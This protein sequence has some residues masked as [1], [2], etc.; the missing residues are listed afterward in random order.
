MVA[1]NAAACAAQDKP[2]APTPK[3]NDAHSTQSS[4]AEKPKASPD[5]PPGTGSQASDPNAQQ[6]ENT[7]PILAFFPN[8]QPKNNTPQTKTRLPPR[9]KNPLTYPQ[10]PNSTPHVATAF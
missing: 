4:S 2:D 7:K 9:E 3:Q 5:P 10:T 8:F 6:A 1:A